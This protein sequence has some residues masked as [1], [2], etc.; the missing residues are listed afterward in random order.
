MT[1]PGRAYDE[2]KTTEPQNPY[3]PEEYQPEPWEELADFME[4]VQR[5][6][7]IQK[8]VEQTLV[9]AEREIEHLVELKAYTAI[10]QLAANAVLKTLHD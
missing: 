3:G 8:D 5:R 1:F 10:R 7:A 6:E 4:E 2:W 9:W